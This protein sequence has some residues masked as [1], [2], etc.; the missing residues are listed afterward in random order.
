MLFCFKRKKNLKIEKRK[1]KKSSNL[2]QQ[3]QENNNLFEFRMKH[4]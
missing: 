4:E 3:S 1:E 2:R